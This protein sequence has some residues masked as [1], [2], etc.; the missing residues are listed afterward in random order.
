M[1]KLRNTRRFIEILHPKTL[2]VK[3]CSLVTLDLTYDGLIHQ[4]FVQFLY[5]I[6]ET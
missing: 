5:H 1:V 6:R 2:L 4:N 3:V